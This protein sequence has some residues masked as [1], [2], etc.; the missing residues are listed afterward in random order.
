MEGKHARVEAA[1]LMVGQGL[2]V[3]DTKALEALHGCRENLGV[4]VWG[5][6][7]VFRRDKLWLRVAS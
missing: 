1:H 5:D 7:P 4:D 2:G 6:G 3:L